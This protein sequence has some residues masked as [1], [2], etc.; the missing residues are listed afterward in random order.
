MDRPHPRAA[1]DGRAGRRVRQRDGDGAGPM[2]RGSCAPRRAGRCRWRRGTAALA[3]TAGL[4]LVIAAARP[5]VAQSCSFS[6]A[7]VDFGNVDMTSG[8]DTTT[9]TTINVFCWGAP[10]RT[11][12][13]C[14]NINA[15]SGGVAGGGDPRYMRQG[16]GRIGYNL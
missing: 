15:G 6:I 9:A 4:G 16:G 8:L 7:D 12:I 2:I 14:P 10:G 13:L 3:A 5:A 11:I 1:H